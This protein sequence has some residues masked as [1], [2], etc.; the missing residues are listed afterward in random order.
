[1]I[2]QNKVSIFLLF[3]FLLNSACNEEW[4]EPEPLSFYAP[5]NVY[6]NEQGFQSLLVTLRKDLRW[7]LDGPNDGLVS[8]LVCTDIAIA[9]P[10]NNR[11][12]RELDVQLTPSTDGNYAMLDYFTN[13]YETIRNANV[14]ISRI[15]QPDW[16]SEQKRNEVLAEGYFHRAYWYYRLVHQYGD[17]PFI[18]QELQEAKLDFFSHSRKTILAKIIED[19]EFAVQNLP[20]TAVPGAVTKY[21]GYHLLAKMYLANSQ[22]SDAVQ[23]ATEVINGPFAL[24]ESRFG[25]WAGDPTR[26]VIWDLHRPENIHDPSNTETILA[27]VDRFEAPEGARTNGLATMRDYNPAWWNGRV[28]DSSGGGGTIAAGEMYDS[29]GRGNGFARGTPYYLYDMWNDPDDLRR[30]D[31]NWVEKEELRY[32]RESSPNFGEPIN[33]D[34]FANPID[35]FQHF[36]AFPHYISY[37]P[38]QDPTANPLGGNAD[39]YVFR[40]AGTYLLRAEAYYWQN[41]LGNAAADLNVVRTRANAAPV[42]AGDVTI[43]LILEDRAKELFAESPR[44]TELARIAFIMADNNLNGYSTENFSDNNF[45]YDHVMAHNV[46]FQ[47]NLLWGVNPCRILPYHVLWPIPASVINSNTLGVI[48]QNEGYVGAENNVDPLTSI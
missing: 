33:P 7:E 24:M 11:S 42:N 12:P 16:S 47:I 48:N 5:E 46:F 10:R 9:S 3:L 2:H 44:K 21:A 13:A 37:V 36:Y 28:R 39:W 17:V 45:Y 6:V 25:S 14:L 31:A 18:G 34:F 27:V 40:L 26:N 43:D 19:M 35:T 22:F 4:L 1:M 20:E 32:N 38:Q 23:A 41:D 30:S 8:E 15:D 29:L